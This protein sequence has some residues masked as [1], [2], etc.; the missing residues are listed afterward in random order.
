MDEVLKVLNEWNE[1]NE[2]ARLAEAALLEALRLELCGGPP[3]DSSVLHEVARLR[4][5]ADE[6]LGASM[7]AMTDCGEPEHARLQ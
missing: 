6:M 3:V 4:A 1:A 7:R 2:K 5:T